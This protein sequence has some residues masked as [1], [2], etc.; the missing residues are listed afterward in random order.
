MHC[1]SFSPGALLEAAK[2]WLLCLSA[3]NGSRYGML[4]CQSKTTQHIPHGCDGSSASLFTLCM[5]CNTSIVC[6]AVYVLSAAWIC[7][8]A[9]ELALLTDNSALCNCFSVH[10]TFAMGRPQSGN[11]P[12]QHVYATARLVCHFSAIQAFHKAH[13]RKSLVP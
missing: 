5:R 6:S 9:S 3:S 1:S 8:A 13:N 2:V 10:S 7:S 12:F 11:L 4:M